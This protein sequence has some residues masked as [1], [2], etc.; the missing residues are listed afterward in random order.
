MRKAARIATYAA[1][2][3][4]KSPTNMHFKRIV[5][6]TAKSSTVATASYAGV[7]LS[8]ARPAK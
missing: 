5:N 7:Q 8:G 1:N 2:C 6:G 3:D 4:V